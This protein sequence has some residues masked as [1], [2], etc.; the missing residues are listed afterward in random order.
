MPTPHARPR[1]RSSHDRVHRLN[2]RSAAVPCEFAGHNSQVALP[3]IFGGRREDLC[4][5]RETEPEHLRVAERTR[6]EPQ[7]EVRRTVTPATDVHATDAADGLDRT[8]EAHDELT[9]LRG[10][11]TV[12]AVEVDVFTTF[13]KELHR[14]CGT[15]PGCEYPP[16]VIDPDVTIVRLATRFAG[17]AAR[18]TGTW[19]IGGCAGLNGADAQISNKGKDR[20]GHEPRQ[21]TI[22]TRR[23]H[24]RSRLTARPS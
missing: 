3:D 17:P 6:E 24:E 11:S 19:P 22:I 20:P 18:L 1:D 13:E 10:T 12:Q 15:S 8:I 14:N 9:Q 16:M 23:S 21:R 5:H 4:P 2:D 7:V